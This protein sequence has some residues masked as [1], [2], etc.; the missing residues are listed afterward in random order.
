LHD[1]CMNFAW[2]LHDF[3]LNQSLKSADN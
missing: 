1:F 3:C 2:F